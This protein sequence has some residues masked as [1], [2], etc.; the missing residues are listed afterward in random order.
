MTYSLNW[1][2]DLIYPGGI[3]SPEFADKL[4]L[5]AHQITDLK[6]MLLLMMSKKTKIFQ[7]LL[8]SLMT[9]KLSFPAYAQLLCSSMPYQQLTIQTLLI[10]LTN[11]SF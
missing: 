3:E 11:K 8:S 10:V 6:I 4:L 7:A 9:T 5:L 2:L 1:D